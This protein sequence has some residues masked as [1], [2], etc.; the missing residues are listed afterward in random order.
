MTNIKS[1]R[2]LLN[3]LRRITKAL[4]YFYYFGYYILHVSF[5]DVELHTGSS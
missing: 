1:N 2:F 5:L 3:D 4:Y